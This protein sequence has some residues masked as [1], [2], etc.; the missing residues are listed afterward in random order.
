M[1]GAAGYAVITPARNEAGNL[2]RLAR[3]LARQTVPP[4]RWVVVDNGSTDGTA[5]VVRQLAAAHPWTLLVEA[6]GMQTPT[7]GAP[8]V[9]AFQAGLAALD[10]PVAFVANH[11]ADITVPPGYYARLLDEFAADPTLGIAGG[12][13]FERHDGV[14]GQRFVTGTTVWGGSRVYR[15]ECLDDVQPIEERLGWDGMAEAKA[16]MCGWTTR[17]V[18]DLPFL[19]HRPEGARD[20]AVWAARVAQG[21]SAHYMGYR[22]WYLVL[23]A[24]RHSLRDPAGMGLLWGYLAAAARREPPCADTRIRDYV[25]RQQ[26]LGNLPARARETLGRARRRAAG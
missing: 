3:S 23:R 10:A 13:C 8:A 11:D 14:W 4:T 24:V 21:R 2:P 15:R 16:N 18:P 7:R 17:L 5:E 1:T 9:R 6:P 25:R 22:P 26:S 20:G 19:H 12:T